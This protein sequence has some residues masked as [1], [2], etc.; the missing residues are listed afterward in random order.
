LYIIYIFVSSIFAGTRSSSSECFCSP[1]PHSREFCP[2]SESKGCWI[3]TPRLTERL[4]YNSSSFSP[5]LWRST[6]RSLW[7]SS[8]PINFTTW[9]RAERAPRARSILPF[10]L[11]TFTSL[12]CFYSRNFRWIKE[13]HIIG[14]HV[15]LNWISCRLLNTPA[16]LGRWRCWQLC[17]DITRSIDRKLGMNDRMI[18]FHFSVFFVVFR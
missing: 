18:Y 10:D 9:L 7:R 8:W 5:R 4:V 13:L 6:A 11:A 15:A 2:R 12:N 16:S 3:S 14:L 17:W 1:L